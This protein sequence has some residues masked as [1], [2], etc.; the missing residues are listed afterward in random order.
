M[1]VFE[2]LVLGLGAT[3]LVL[4]IGFSAFRTDIRR[5]LDDLRR[6]AD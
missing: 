5:V 1:R 3:A 6:R 4:L 2:D